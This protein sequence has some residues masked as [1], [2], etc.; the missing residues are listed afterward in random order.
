M[1]RR[2]PRRFP[3]Q[4]KIQIPIDRSLPTAGSFLQ[5]FRTPTA[6]ET[7]QAFCRSALQRRDQQPDVRV[8]AR[9]GRNQNGSFRARSTKKLTLRPCWTLR[10][11]PTPNRISGRINV[12]R[13]VMPDRS[14][15]SAGRWQFLAY[16]ID[17]R[18]SGCRLGF[19]GA[20]GPWQR[21]ITNDFSSAGRSRSVRL[22]STGC[23][24]YH[25]SSMVIVPV[26]AG[27]LGQRVRIASHAFHSGSC[28][29]DVRRIS[30]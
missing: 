27:N 11:L 4:P 8:V 3:H 26:R 1:P 2:P 16:S 19:G 20:A 30:R 24:R 7:L 15:A 21:G 23:N 17:R 25:R 13:G 18:S 5:E 12:D 22:E 29:L 14:S 6:P 9:S 10:S 28:L